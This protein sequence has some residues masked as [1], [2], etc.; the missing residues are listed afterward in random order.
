MGRIL[1]L[2][3]RK[4]TGMQAI[5]SLMQGFTPDPSKGVDPQIEKALHVAKVLLSRAG[6]MSTAR[7]QRKQAELDRMVRNPADKATLTEMTDEAFRAQ[8]ARLAFGQLMEVFRERGVPRFFSTTDRFLLRLLGWIGSVAPGTAMLLFKEYLRR[9]SSEVI[10]PGERDPLVRMLQSRGGEGVRMNVNFLGEAILSEA[11][12]ERRLKHYLQALQWPEVEVVSVKISTLYSQISP[13]ARDHTVRVLAERLERMFLTA[14]RAHFVR[15]S[16]E[17]VPKFIYLDMEE[18][19]DKELT[20]AAFMCALDRPGLLEVRAGIALQ[21]YIPDS[22]ETLQ[23]LQNWAR[24]R[25]GA[26]GGRITIRLVKGANLEM[27]RAEAS[28]RGWPQAPYQTKSETDA[29]FKRMLREM[30]KPENLAAMDVGV[31]SHNLFELAYALVLT[32]EAGAEKQVQFE[33]LEG[34]ANHQ[35]R[36]LGD[37]FENI[38]L[39]APACN[40]ENFVNAIGYLI[41]R[42]DENTGPENFLRHSFGLQPGTEEW[43]RLE[44]DFAA[45][46][47]AMDTVRRS[48]RR[49][50]NRRHPASSASPISPDWQQFQNEPDTDFSLPENGVWAGE[51]IARWRDL[52]GE[53][54]IRVPVVVDGEEIADTGGRGECLD[55]S[56]P[57][58]VVGIYEQA[59]EALVLRAVACAAADPAGWRKLAPEARFELLGRVAEELRAARGDLIGAALADGGKTVAESDPEISEAI[60]FADFYPASARYWQELPTLEARGK[61]VVVVVSPWNFPIAI[62]CG[63]IVAGLAAGNCVILKPASDTVLVAWELCKCFWRAG[64]SRQVLQ[65]LPCAGGGA[66]RVLVGHPLVDA[67]VLTGGTQT[68]LNMLGSNP[69]MALH[70]ETGGKDCTIVTALSDRDQAIKHVLHSA[71]SHAGQKCSAT[72][73]L[74]L[75]AE[76]YDD[77]EFRRTLCEGAASMIVGPVWNLE[78]RMGPLIRPPSGDLHNALQTLE[79][80]EEWA[81]MPRRSLS[82]PGVWSPGIKYGVTP[83]SY[84]HLTEFF[85]PVLGVMRYETLDEAIALVN[86]TGYGLTSGLES[87]DEREW[88]VWKAGIKSGNLYINRV[89][90]GAVV[91]RQPFGGFGRSVFGPGLKAGGP[92]YVAQLMDFTDR[93]ATPVDGVPGDEFIRKMLE[94]LRRRGSKDHARALGAALSYEAAW[95]E[96]FGKEHDHFKLVG[97]DNIRRYLP[98]NGICVRIHGD[99]TP[100]DVY[101]RVLAGA[102]TGRQVAVSIPPGPLQRE[103]IEVMTE[104]ASVDSA[105]IVIVRQSDAQLAQALKSG[106]LERLRYAAPDRVPIE[107]CQAGNQA[108]GNIVSR[109]VSAEGRL[110]LLWYLREQSISID[111]HRHGNLG[112]RGCEERA[113]VL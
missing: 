93:P 50:Q 29:N 11:E 12:A 112:I 6:G 40:R 80:G 86:Q 10:L 63:G 85:G 39:Y 49:T 100:L 108:C 53:R 22:F 37:V 47:S 33:M 31:A 71:F 99:D 61:G 74:L 7:E 9:E 1:A 79:S 91:L 4:D 110:E 92:N 107:V 57:G 96:E 32:A 15:R 65:F 73:L 17:L 14:Q 27:E 3:S 59:T 52:N 106:A 26:G 105:R 82:N 98:L 94:I 60:D 30:L 58:V 84:T 24:K 66:G 97:Q 113:A 23:V 28:V 76:V 48:P 78:T 2:I 46:F 42:L 5:Q 101:L 88:H 103:E 56:R 83:G 36:A 16:G 18:Y 35:R 13:L 109:R 62:P 95:R 104:C 8:D 34:M 67:V 77:P 102:I 54:A 70:A 20:A 55:P 43:L 90:T 68:A 69:R 72:S 44:K 89:T 41:R 64:I 87:L 81:L 45:S 21:S 25:V 38:L 51:I 111:Y 75:E 19:R